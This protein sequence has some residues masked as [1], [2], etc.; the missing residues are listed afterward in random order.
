MYSYIRKHK[1][2]MGLYA[3]RLIQAGLIDA[4]GV[5]ALQDNYRDR[6]DHGEPVPKSALGMIGNEF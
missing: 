6:L 1:T 2:T 4:A 3:E 5:T